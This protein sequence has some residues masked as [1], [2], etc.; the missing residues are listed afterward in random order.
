[1]TGIVYIHVYRLGN[2]IELEDSM[3]YLGVIQYHQET[4]NAEI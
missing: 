4:T 1:M 3:E 2:V